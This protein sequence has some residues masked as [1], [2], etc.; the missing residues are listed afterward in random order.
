MRFTYHWETV[1]SFVPFLDWG[2]IGSTDNGI[3]DDGVNN[4][5]NDMIND[6]TTHQHTLIHAIPIP[7]A[8][9]IP[10]AIPVQTISKMA[11]LVIQSNRVHA[12]RHCYCAGYVEAEETAAGSVDPGE[13]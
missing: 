13:G 9:P 3:T 2:G 1:Y 11:I 7:N 4:M 10:A 12:H 5:I 8:I 6:I